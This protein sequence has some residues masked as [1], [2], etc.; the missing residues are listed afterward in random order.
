M[1]IFIVDILELLPTPSQVAAL[2]QIK[3]SSNE[4]VLW[5]TEDQIRRL[6]AEPGRRQQVK[7]GEPAIWVL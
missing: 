6:G 4:D 1:E 3:D 2:R 7:I 5:A